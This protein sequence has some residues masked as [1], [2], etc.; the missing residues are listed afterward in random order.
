MFLSLKEG[1]PVKMDGV[2]SIASGLAAPFAG[3][4][5]YAVISSLAECV[6]LVND[7]QI[8][9]GVKILYENGLVVETAG[10]AAFAALKFG[11]V[12]ETQGKRVV[13]IISGSNVSVEELYELLKQ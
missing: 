1:Q 10:A 11:K 7:E 5:A 3:T 13:V 4:H 2:K 12:A 8:R 9:E 6:V